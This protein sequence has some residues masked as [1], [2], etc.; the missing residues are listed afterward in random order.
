MGGE[1]KERTREDEGRGVNL[2]ASPTPQ[3]TPRYDTEIFPPPPSRTHCY[4]HRLLDAGGAGGCCGGAGPEDDEPPLLSR[5]EEDED[6]DEEAGGG[7]G[8]EEPPSRPP[9]ARPSAPSSSP[10]KMDAQM[11]ALALAASFFS[12]PPV[13]APAPVPVSLRDPWEALAAPPLAL[14]FSASLSR[15]SERSFSWRGGSSRPSTTWRHSS[16][17]RVSCSSCKVEKG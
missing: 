10:P 16:A 5:D 11:P 1:G 14:P 17:V 12:A 13:P 3:H 8:A 2:S 6:E 7:T 9:A 4:A 15:R